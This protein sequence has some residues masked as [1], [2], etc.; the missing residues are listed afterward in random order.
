MAQQTALATRPNQQPARLQHGTDGQLAEAALGA[1]ATLE[2]LQTPYCTAIRVQV[3]RSLTDVE[4]EAVREAEMMGEHFFYAWSVKDRHKGRSRIA[5]LSTDGAKMLQRL[6]GNNAVDVQVLEDS[7]THWLFRAVF[8]DLESGVTIPRLFKQRKPTA[9]I[10]EMDLD[11]FEDM[12]F[13]KGQSKAIRNVIKDALPAWLVSKCQLVAQKAAENKATKDPEGE[14][15]EIIER[16]TAIGLNGG[17]LA[18]KMGKRVQDYTAADIVTAKALLTTVEQGHAPLAIIFPAAEPKPEA[19]QPDVAAFDAQAETP[20]A[21]DDIP[22][23]W[24]VGDAAEGEDAVAPM[25]PQSPKFPVY[26]ARIV[27]AGKTDSEDA[28]MAIGHEIKMS[29]EG[30]ELLDDEAAEL[31]DI[32]K[33]TMEAML[34][35]I[36][37]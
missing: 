19:A 12:E 34:R 25:P 21:A 24:Q 17:R 3:K 30:G 13:Q 1:G 18:R 8:I 9:S 37:K 5:G 27:E 6:W 35:R 31:K 29:K 7:D 36:N 10:G 15:Q 26:A 11:R 23:D 2:R 33:R 16:A 14:K 32:W 20:P 4:R 28:L 22:A